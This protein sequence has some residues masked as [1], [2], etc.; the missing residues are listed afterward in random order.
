MLV[1]NRRSRTIEFVNQGGAGCFL[2][3]TAQQW[4]ATLQQ[5]EQDSSSS[6]AVTAGAVGFVPSGIDSAV[7]AAPLAHTQDSPSVQAAAEV[8]AGPFSISPAYLE[9]PAG[10][11]AVLAVEFS[12]DELGRQSAEFV[13]VFD[14]C[15]ASPLR[16]EGYGEQVQVQLVGLDDREW[17][18]QDAQMP[19]WLG[20]VRVLSAFPKHLPPSRVPP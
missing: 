6:S 8:R 13:L 10:A 3:M 11:A 16:V 1:G 7:Q 12:P 14:N 9:L 20:Q 2:L 19:L 4:A 17:L 5:H 15:T 18:P